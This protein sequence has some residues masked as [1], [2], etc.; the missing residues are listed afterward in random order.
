MSAAETI[1]SPEAVTG[2]HGSSLQRLVT[3]PTPYHSEEGITIYCGDCRQIVPTL[4]KY[5]LLLTDPPYGINV[6][7]TMAKQGGTQYGKAAAPKRHYAATE[8]DKAPPPRWLL[9]MLC[10]AAKW[11]ILWG[12]NY[13]AGLPAARG[14]LVWDKENGDNNFADCELAW[15]NLD[16]AVRKK[17]HMWNGMLRKNGEDREHPTQKPL[18]VMQWCLGLVPEAKTVLD[19]YMGSGTTLVAAKLRGWQATGIEINEEYCEIAKRRLSQG[20]LLAV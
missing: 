7:A 17:A 5:D 9:D 3:P 8:W 15:T 6:D 19:P 20:V 11:Q 16:I 2:A 10:D 12:G 14:W 1:L 13:Y 18:D 4:G